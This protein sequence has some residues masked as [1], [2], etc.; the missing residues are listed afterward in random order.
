MLALAH[1]TKEATLVNL[2]DFNGAREHFE[3]VLEFFDP[4]QTT[5][6]QRYWH[7]PGVA[8]RCFG[9]WALCCLGYPDQA[10]QRIDEALGARER[11][12]IRT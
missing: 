6:A 2:G 12:G 11:F 7:D 9:A 1:W 8:G 5:A 3:R 4:K 10:L